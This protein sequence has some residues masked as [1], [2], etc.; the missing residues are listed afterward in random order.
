MRPRPTPRTPRDRFK[1]AAAAARS[2]FSRYP[3]ALLDSISVPATG[4]GAGGACNN[5]GVGCPDLSAHA[6]AALWLGHA[7][8]LLRVGGA[9]ILTDPV[10]SQRIGMS[11][12]SRTV[13]LERLAPPVLGVD[14]LPPIDFI[15][16]SHA[17]FDHLD[18]PTLSRL[19]SPKTTVVTARHMRRLVP[20]GFGRVLE[21]DWS[22]SADLGPVRVSAIEPAHWGARTAIDRHRGYN[23][24]VIEPTGAAGPG[25]GSPGAKRRVLFG[26][27]T[28]FTR[29]FDHLDG[30]KLAILGIGAYDPWI[31][32]HADPEQAWSMFTALEGGQGGE[33]LLPVHHSTF[34]LSDE[35][36][37]EP[38]Q[39]LLRAAGD[40]SHRVIVKP[41]GELWT[42]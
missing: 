5:G 30:V 32:A 31:H 18:K 41:A 21:V 9:T 34:K 24:Y 19:A 22:Q 3:R 7:T 36:V 17:H 26:G 1:R 2:S 4:R 27:D 25:E 42:G 35:H 29:A 40:Q 6:L 23:S 33:H 14:E 12:G 8:V 11:F 13:G 37:D 28:A 20:R 16:L 10:L 38:M 39:R 15:L